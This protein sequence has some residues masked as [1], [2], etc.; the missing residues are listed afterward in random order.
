M[1]AKIL[2]SPG[3][4]FRDE[5]LGKTY[6]VESIDEEDN[7][8]YLIIDHVHDSGIQYVAG[9]VWRFDLDGVEFLE[10]EEMEKFEVGSKVLLRPDS[11][12]VGSGE[13][14]NS[15]PVNVVGVV[16]RYAEH[17]LER[18]Q[19]GIHVEWANGKIN[20]Y[21][22]ADLIFANQKPVAIPVKEPRTAKAKQKPK[23]REQTIVYF[24]YVDGT[25]YE[26][27]RAKG[28]VINADHKAIH[29]DSERSLGKGLVVRENSTVPFKLLDAVRVSTPDG[30]FCYYFTNGELTGSAREFNARLPFKTQMH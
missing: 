14:D 7:D 18:G 28:V 9:T 24:V 16:I 26:Q 5:L 6:Q 1:R 17:E 21:R 8:V 19:L 12:W 29:V 4:S 11:E 22:E 25:D 10:E 2:K 15:N 13:E 27:R 20:S 3:Y 30:E 23:R